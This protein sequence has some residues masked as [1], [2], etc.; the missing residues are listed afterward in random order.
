LFIKINSKEHQLMMKA[1]SQ[2][3]D[4]VN[5]S[6]CGK[7]MTVNAGPGTGK[8]ETLSLIANAKPGVPIVNFCFNRNTKLQADKRMPTWVK[9]YT[10]HGAAYAYCGKYY[11]PKLKTK[12]LP[13]VIANRFG[14]DE[15]VATVAKYTLR[16]FAVS[17]S[18]FITGWH[19]PKQAVLGQKP[20]VRETFKNDVVMVARK[21]WRAA[22]DHTDREIGIE[23]DFYAKRWADEGAKLG[24]RYETVMIDESQDMVK[25]NIKAISSISGQKIAVGD[26]NQQ[27]YDYREYLRLEIDK[28][29]VACFGEHLPG[30]QK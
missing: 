21:V 5:A 8:T 27:L 25:S 14:C 20:E 23:H 22:M 2:Q 30:I 13:R 12:I 16:R 11:A 4:A 17:D 28:Q 9:N 1:T 6:K 3:L 29:F 24:A 7:D 15:H 26:R 10:F 18:E 19:V